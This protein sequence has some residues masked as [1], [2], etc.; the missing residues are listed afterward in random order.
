MFYAVSRH[1]ND[2][3]FGMMISKVENGFKKKNYSCGMMMMMFS[4]S[5]PAYPIGVCYAATKT[6]HLQLL[7][8]LV[9]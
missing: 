7:P 2:N 4:F 1:F 6:G 9:V 3:K 8:A 5:S